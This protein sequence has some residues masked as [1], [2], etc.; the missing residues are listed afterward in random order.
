VTSAPLW[1]KRRWGDL[2][3]YDGKGVDEPIPH[4]LEDVEERNQGLN[5]LKS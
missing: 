4:Y 5:Q 3:S 2:Y 1:L